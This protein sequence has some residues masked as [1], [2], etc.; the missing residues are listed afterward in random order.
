MATINRT[1]R[2]DKQNFNQIESDNWS[3]IYLPAICAGVVMTVVLFLAVS[4]SKKSDNPAAKISAP[5]TAALQP[6]APSP[7][8]AVFPEKPKKAIKKHR[9]TTATYVNGTYGVSLTYPRKYSLQ[10]A[11]KQKNMPIDISLAKPGAVEI[12]SLNMPDGLYPQTDFSSALLNVS[13]KQDM[14]ADECGQFAQLSNKATTDK[15]ADSDKSAKPAA[16][17]A[18]PSMIKL[19][20]NEFSE[21]EQMSGSDDR[22]SDT[23]YFHLFKNSACYEFAL[24]VETSRKTEQ[25]LA[26]VDR[27]KI[28]K[29]LEK[30]LA[31]A[32]IKDV[33]LP[34]TEN[35][36]KTTAPEPSAMTQPTVATPLSTT[37]Q[38]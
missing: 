9:P 3:G 32:Q 37:Q 6:P 16:D 12:A 22:Q 1:E 11:D 29:Q 13:V 23:K 35:V 19:G 28:F 33:D 7:A 10:S 18:K 27:D 38:N 24:D 4:C 5:E 31:S 8:A 26:Q 17:S 25:D 30:I 20:T 21:V 14:T 34:G 2:N 15:A 36:E